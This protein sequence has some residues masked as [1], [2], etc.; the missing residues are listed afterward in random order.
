MPLVAADLF[1]ENGGIVEASFYPGIA[2]QDI[3]ARLDVYILR[4]RAAAVAAGS[5][6]PERAAR[7]WANHQVCLSVFLRLSSAPASVTLADSGSRAYMV[8]QIQN[9]KDLADGYL[10]EFE[11]VLAEVAPVVVAPFVYGVISSFRSPAV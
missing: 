11:D 9:F 4:G 2:V 8:T 5:L 1:A 7:A 10:A 6:D 3:L